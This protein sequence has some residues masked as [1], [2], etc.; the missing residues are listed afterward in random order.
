MTREPWSRGAAAYDSGNKLLRE[1]KSRTRVWGAF[2]SPGSPIKACRSITDSAP[3]G[4]DD[5][6]NL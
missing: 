1:M 2:E 5:H 6:F 4:N 3:S